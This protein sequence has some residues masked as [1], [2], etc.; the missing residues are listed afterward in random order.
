MIKFGTDGWRAVIA[1]E[2]T[3]DNVAIVAQA[4]ADYIKK[5]K[6]KRAVVG[7]DARFLSREFALTCA[8]VLAGNKIKA[9]V[10]QICIPTPVVSFNNRYKKFDLGI[11]ITASHNPGQFNGIKLKTPDGGAADKTITDQVEKLLY[12]R[13]P[14]L[15]DL[16]TAQKK[17]LLTI[18]DITA[19]NKKFLEKFVNIKKIRKLKLRILMDLMHGSGGKFAEE[20]ISSKTVKFDYLRSEFNPSFGGGHPEPVAKNLATLIKKVKKEKYDLGVALDGDADRI[21]LVDSKGNYVDAQEILPLLALHMVKNRGESSGIGKTV[22]GSDL[23]DKV[24]AALGVGCFETKVGFKYISSLFKEKLISIGGE[25]AGGI[26]YKGYI[27]ERDGSASLLMVLE[28]MAY[29]KKSFDRLL[30]EMRK[31]YGRRYYAR[32]SVSLGSLKKGLN[33]LKLPETLLGKKVERI[34]RMDGIKLITRDSW[35]IFRKSGTEAIVRVYAEAG[36]LK[37]RDNLI[38]LGKRMID[39]L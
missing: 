6:G 34:N 3:F 27:P 25:E 18:K 23:I 28:M 35:L 33:K 22:V 37:E 24:A 30:R 26:G 8:Q 16:E 19:D 12:K 1:R 10:S 13:K 11:M 4:V 20:I 38:A 5:N 7:Y 39:A 2:F 21:A 32:I 36:T 31:T 9:I 14:K 17:K 15:L 29:E